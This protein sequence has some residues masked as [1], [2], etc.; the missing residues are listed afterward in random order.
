MR[1]AL[2]RALSLTACTILALA[3][4]HLATTPATATPATGR[5]AVTAASGYWI[6]TT[7]SSSMTP[8]TIPPVCVRA[9]PTRFAADTL[10]T[11]PDYCNFDFHNGPATS[12]E[13]RIGPLP[14][15]EPV[16]LYAWSHYAPAAHGS[17][18]LGA[19]GG[20][21][22][23]TEAAVLRP[24]LSGLRAPKL[25]MDAPE[26]VVVYAMNPA[27]NGLMTGCLSNYGLVGGL[28]DSDGWHRHCGIPN[29]FVM[30]QWLGPYQWDIEV[31]APG[32]ATVW[33]PGSASSRAGGTP[34]TPGP[35]TWFEVF[36]TKGAKA[37]GTAVS[38]VA[39]VHDVT[40]FHAVTGDII[41][42]VK[43]TGAFSFD[44]LPTGSV[45][46]RARTT[47]GFTCWYTAPNGRRAPSAV[48]QASAGKAST[49]LRIDVGPGCRTAAPD[50]LGT[51]VKR[52]PRGALFR[53]P[54]AVANGAVAPRPSAGASGTAVDTVWGSPTPAR[55][56]LV[57]R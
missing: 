40:V 3:A 54:S 1:I 46:L 18:W 22:R 6:D 24:T 28:E 36:M 34:V 29:G 11:P 25:V 38:T 42:Q 21:G 30:Q 44:T 26:D 20:V 56:A 14:T 5:T 57:K 19:R 47:D 45:F 27:T 9:V 31:S 55:R 49:G 39:P 32:Y 16:Q 17:Q 48:L 35:D 4:G 7:V 53:T 37:S 10:E 33:L 23:R 8:G 52:A 43:T 12:A 2:R 41:A 15:D 13:L 51:P 50:L